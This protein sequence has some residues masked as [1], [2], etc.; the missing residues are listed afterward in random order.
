MARL[1]RVTHRVRVPDGTTGGKVRVEYTGPYVTAAAAAGGQYEG[2]LSMHSPGWAEMWDLALEYPLQVLGAEPGDPVPPI[3]RLVITPTGPG[4]RSEPIIVS[5]RPVDDGAGVWGLQPAAAV[6]QVATPAQI[7]KLGTALG[8]YEQVSASLQA[9]SRQ[10][11]AAAEL[12]TTSAG[13]QALGRAPAPGDPAGTYRVGEQDIAWDGSAETGRTDVLVTMPA[14]RGRGPVYVPDLLIGSQSPAENMHRINEA[15]AL[16]RDRREFY[17]PA[18]YGPYL[19]AHPNPASGLSGLY[20]HPG[21]TIRG[22]GPASV[23]RYAVPN[24]QYGHLL[25]PRHT[26]G[27]RHEHAR[28]LDFT[29]DHNSTEHLPG[30]V[31]AGITSTHYIHVR[32]TWRNIPLV[33]LFADSPEENPTV[34]AVI[35]SPQVFTSMGVALSFFNA[36]ESFQFSGTGRFEDLT[37]DGIAFQEGG[38]GY[39]KGHV[40]SGTYV[41]R[42]C[43]QRH[44]VPGAHEGWSTPVALRMVGAEDINW[45]G[46]IDADGMASSVVSS[47]GTRLLEGWPKHNGGRRNSN[48][49]LGPIHARRT[50]RD[51]SPIEGHP[52]PGH[53]ITVVDTQNMTMLG[54]VIEDGL[55]AAV[56]V[57][58]SDGV[59]VKDLQARGCQIGLRAARGSTVRVEGGDYSRN[60]AGVLAEHAGTWVDLRGVT[61]NNNVSGIYAASG[62]LITGHDVIALDNTGQTVVQDVGTVQVSGI[63][64]A[65]GPLSMRGT[66]TIAAGQTD[67]LLNHFLGQAAGR[68]AVSVRDAPA[69]VRALAHPN[70][71]LFIA[72]LSEPQP[73]DTQI[74]WEAWV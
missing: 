42:R 4:V 36:C 7:A 12:A 59:V 58:T 52:N 27:V 23:L 37:D 70:P 24:T 19:V 28:L 67:L 71:A 3:V 64:T 55:G 22:D 31:T 33:A 38:T 16:H 39:Q 53:T 6:P 61:A 21:Q 5:G 43:G 48:I 57:E 62:S 8:E 30:T 26:A 29:L 46:V 66:A 50:G 54:G 41:F 74:D 51:T 73:G 1:L 34:G 32:L 25:L 56:D 20:Y 15:L 65:P 10:A 49:T 14:L 9:A 68:I 72:R 40:G 13:V 47:Q 18:E 44:Y 63:R 17:L 45:Q 35:E 11:L 2:R 60:E 69:S